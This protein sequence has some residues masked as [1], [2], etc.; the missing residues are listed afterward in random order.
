MNDH[1]AKPVNPA[2]L[3]RV[4]GRWCPQH[5][6]EEAPVEDAPL[7]VDEADLA[8][9]GLDVRDGL[10]RT[11]GNR[12]FYLQ[13]LARFRDG[14]RDTV[15]NIRGALASDRVVA[16]RFAHTLKGV[17]GLV[18]AKAMQELSGRI[19]AAI[20]N[21]MAPEALQPLLQE[22]DAQMQS[23]CKAIGNALPPAA[24]F[25]LPENSSRAIAHPFSDDEGP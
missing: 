13:M 1:L 2:K 23:L 15:A 7:P 9:E 18:G 4:I 6:C 20:R 17:A 10:S 8:I 5:V 22:L 11:L 24:G 19:E 14:Q 3:Y 16:E 21:G 25:R 12:D